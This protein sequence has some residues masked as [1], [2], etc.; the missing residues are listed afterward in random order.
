MFKF[1]PLEN[2]NH[3]LLK[4]KKKSNAI[5]SGRRKFIKLPFRSLSLV[6]IS[7]CKK[8]QMLM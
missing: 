7:A 5:W 6:V 2:G 4:V 8:A 3:V 1:L